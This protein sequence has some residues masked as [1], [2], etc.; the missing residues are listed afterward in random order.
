[1]KN[2]FKN[3][4]FGLFF[5]LCCIFVL[6][7]SSFKGVY[8]NATEGE[9]ED[10]ENENVENEETLENEEEGENVDQDVVEGESELGFIEENWKT[11]V[12]S[13]LGTLGGVGGLLGFVLKAMKNANSVTNKFKERET[14]DKE[15]QEKLGKLSEILTKAETNLEN[16]I[17][18]LKESEDKFESKMNELYDLSKDELLDMHKEFENLVKSFKIMVN[19]NESLVKKGIAEKINAI[20][21]EKE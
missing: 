16:A 9:I 12:A 7:A 5:A 10:V 19:N 18:K 1:M 20:I 8:V 2:S 3:A 13:L 21:D 11:L 6:S 14:E 4:I 17:N 15:K